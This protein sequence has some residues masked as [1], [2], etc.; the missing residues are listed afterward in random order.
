MQLACNWFKS[1]KLD[2]LLNVVQTSLLNLYPFKKMI[3]LA[4]TRRAQWGDSFCKQTSVANCYWFV[5]LKWAG[6]LAVAGQ[7]LLTQ[8]SDRISPE[9]C[10]TW[11][12]ETTRLSM[13]Q[14]TKINTP[15]GLILSDIWATRRFRLATARYP[16]C[17]FQ[18]K[19]PI[20]IERVWKMTLRTVT[21]FK[22]QLFASSLF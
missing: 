12:Q 18:P 14:C 9:E 13:W 1:Y 7:N 10:K 17:P 21:R 4:F 5:W 3:G 16:P 22:T 20:T 15:S 6:Y 19:R 8:I 11:C 2:F